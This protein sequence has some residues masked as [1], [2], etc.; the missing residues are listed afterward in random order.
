MNSTLALPRRPRGRPT[1]AAEAAY[2]A[3]LHEWCAAVKEL[4]SRL[5]FRVG[6]RGWCYIL[7]QHGLAKGDF[8]DAEQL[9]TNCRK[10]GLLPLN[11]CADDASRGFSGGQY[12]TYSANVEAEAASH[13]DYLGSAW[14]SYTPFGFWEDQP[15]YLE[16][17]V[18]KVDLKSL[19]API[20]SR[21]FIPYANAKGWSDKNQLAGI[22]CR[23]AA[24]VERG[25]Q[26]VLL[27]CGDHDPSGLAISDFLVL[28]CV[29]LTHAV[30]QTY[31]VKWDYKTLIIDRF[32]LNRDFIEANR[33][34]WIDGLMTGSGKNLADPSH[35]DHDKPYVADYLREHGAR[36]VEANALVVAP[37]AGRNLLLE[38]IFKY[39]DRDALERYEDRLKAP[40]E[41]LRV[42]M[43]KQMREWKEDDDQT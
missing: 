29:A 5:K 19:F 7:E 22:M 14:R 2:D 6:T 1:A 27:Y 43:L 4:N 8:D 15:Y 32:G 33:L 42:E 30:E 40:R 37:E 9:I 31:G 28:N 11:I 36:K 26:P 38:T 25:K 24:A 23:T 20:C 35:K 3:E 41:A 39:I 16:L 17:L 34:S 21:Y 18:E 10:D 13:M 12:L